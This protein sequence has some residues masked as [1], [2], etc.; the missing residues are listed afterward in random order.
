MK[1]EWIYVTGS[2]GNWSDYGLLVHPVRKVAMVGESCFDGFYDDDGDPE[3]DES[4]TV[5]SIEEALSRVYPNEEDMAK[6][7]EAV[8]GNYSNILNELSERRRPK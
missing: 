5:I 2:S 6:I 3:W 7:M 1:N 4:E 8:P